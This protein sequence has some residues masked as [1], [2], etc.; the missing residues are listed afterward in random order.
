MQEAKKALGTVALSEET[1]RFAPPEV[2]PPSLQVALKSALNKKF[3][4][5]IVKANKD[6]GHGSSER[7]TIFIDVEP[8]VNS[9]FVNSYLDA[10]CFKVS[11]LSAMINLQEEFK[12]DPG[13]HVGIIACNR[14]ELVDSILVRL[15]D[16]DDY[17][18][19]LQLQLMKE[20]HT[21]SG[22]TRDIPCLN[23]PL[24]TVIE[25]Q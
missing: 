1:V 23:E 18:K 16:V 17:D 7:S 10:T 21:S 3:I 13:D 19:P 6:L 5:C 2:N 20:T 4:Q 12:Y 24:L 15:K 9:K 14:K 8:K 25:K 22:K 11:I